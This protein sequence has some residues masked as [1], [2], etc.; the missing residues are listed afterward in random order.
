MC[1]YGGERISRH[2]SLR[3]SLFATAQAAGLSPQKEVRALLPGTDLR[4]ADILIPRWDTGR[5]W[6]WDFSITHA[7]QKSTRA[8]E[9]EN[10]GYSLQFA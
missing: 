9:A 8:R 5:D 4:P 2:H 6:A 1:G 10:P 3:D 7:M